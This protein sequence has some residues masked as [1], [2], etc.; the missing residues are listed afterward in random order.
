MRESEVTSEARYNTGANI[1]RKLQ[2]IENYNPT[3]GSVIYIFFP[4]I[5]KG[6]QHSARAQRHGKKVQ[7]KGPFSNDPPGTR[8]HHTGH[9]SPLIT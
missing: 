9:G 3:I 6:D 5:K 8:P 1:G 4:P 7:A 2:K